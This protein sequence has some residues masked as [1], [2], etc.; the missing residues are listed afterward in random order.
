M[1]EFFVMK[2]I[3]WKICNFSWGIVVIFL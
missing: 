3:T 1:I 2:F